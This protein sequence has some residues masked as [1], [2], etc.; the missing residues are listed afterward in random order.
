MDSI[1]VIWAIP[2][3]FSL[4]EFEEWNILDWYKRHYINLP[5]STKFSIHLHI[6]FFCAVGFLLTFIAYQLNQTF[7]FSLIISFLSGFILLNTF[8]H[9]VWQFSLKRIPRVL[10][11]EL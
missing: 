8:Q 6:I 9:I 1:N 3:F 10:L 7:F 5:G 11:Q 2:I 4:H